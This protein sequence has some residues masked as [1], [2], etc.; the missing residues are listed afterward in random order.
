MSSEPGCSWPS[1]WWGDELEEMISSRLNPCEELG[2][3]CQK[4]WSPIYENVIP[5][6]VWLNP[7]GPG[8]WPMSACLSFFLPAWPPKLPSLALWPTSCCPLHLSFVSNSGLPLILL[9]P[10]TCLVSQPSSRD[11][12]P[13]SHFQPSLGLDHLPCSCFLQEGC[14]RQC[15]CGGG[16]HKSQLVFIP[17][18]ASA[19]STCLLA[20][21]QWLTQ[22]PQGD[23]F[24]E[25]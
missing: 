2:R 20:D 5:R 23:G 7:C 16:S 10:L 17:S 6:W 25:S 12:H 9:S 14:C 1:G 21:L 3:G 22:V 13:F 4:S 11:N 24:P 15:H 8:D 19:C 18:L